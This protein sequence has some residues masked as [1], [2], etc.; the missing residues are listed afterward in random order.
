MLSN[1][2]NSLKLLFLINPKSGNNTTDWH[3][4]I[5]NYFN[6]SAYK[7]QLFELPNPCEPNKIKEAIE[8]Y[9]PHRVIAVGGDGT[10]KL[11]AQCLLHTNIPLGILP[12]GSANGMAK[13]LNIPVN[14]M[15][16]LDVAVSGETKRI[17]LVKVN[18][19]ICIH[20][21][22]IGFNAFVVKKFEADH[23]RGMWG[24]IKA[25]WKVLWKRPVM[26]VKIQTDETWVKRNAGMIVIANATKYGTGALINPRGKLD[27]QLFEVIVVKK[28]SVKE[29]FK[30]MFTHTPYDKSKIELFQTS[31]LHIQSRKRV[32]FQVDGEYLGK[33]NNINATLMP[34]A[35]EV[36]V[37]H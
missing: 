24:Y 5:Q 36:I 34:N 13:E 7:V 27:D 30:M 2:N 19:E 35:L 8:A 23:G 14:I 31:S 26:Q 9:Q 33:V 37:P 15:R 25:F 10:V 11:A 18:D 3:Q 20:L 28:I 4:Q 29:I 21:S 22:D 16:A 6:A 1:E 12:A 17:H 32:H